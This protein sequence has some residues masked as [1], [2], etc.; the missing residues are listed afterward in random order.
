MFFSRIH[1]IG[2]A[3]GDRREI[4]LRNWIRFEPFTGKINAVSWWYFVAAIRSRRRRRRRRRE[5][6]REFF[7]CKE[8]QFLAPFNLA[9]QPLP[10]SFLDFHPEE[11]RTPHPSTR[12]T[13]ILYSRVLPASSPFSNFPFSY[14]SLR[15]ISRL[16]CYVFSS[17]FFSCY[18]HLILSLCAHFS[19]SAFFTTMTSWLCLSLL[20]LT[21]VFLLSRM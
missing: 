1:F 20:R 12:S 11:A 15:I 5:G 2:Y 13:C 8:S 21:I 6:L 17:S 16:G 18:F 10:I 7:A 9:F 3:A 4:R 19:I 14:P